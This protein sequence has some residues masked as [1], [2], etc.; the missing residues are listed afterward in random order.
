MHDAAGDMLGHFINESLEIQRRRMVGLV[1]NHADDGERDVAHFVAD[2]RDGGAFHFRAEGLRQGLAQGGGPGR[3]RDELIPADHEAPMHPRLRETETRPAFAGHVAQKFP[4]QVMRRRGRGFRMQGR[5]KLRLCQQ[6]NLEPGKQRA[7]IHVVLDEAVGDHHIPDA[8]ARV[9]S[10][11]HPGQNDLRAAKT[12]QQQKRGGRRR[13]L[14][15]PGEHQ[16]DLLPAPFALIKRPQ[17][18]LDRTPHLHGPLHQR[19]FLRHGSEN[20]KLHP[21]TQAGIRLCGYHNCLRE[22]DGAA[23]RACP[24]RGFA[25]TLRAMKKVLLIALAI[26]IV[27]AGSVL[28]VLRGMG[29][30]D[31]AL[32]L[33]A[34]T[35]AMAS[36]PD[37]PRSFLRWPQ[38]TLAKIG[39]EPQLKAF[40]EQPFKY[41]TQQ[42]GGDEAA[43]I[44]WSLKPGRIFAA[45][46]GVSSKDAAI[47][48]G[49]Q[50]WGGKPAHDAA[51]A[52]LRQEIALQGPAAEVKH[53]DYQGADIAS[54]VHGPVS[55]YNASHGQWGFISNNLP[56]LQEALDRA[57]GRRKE[58]SL[59]DSA[60]YKQVV[61]KL[62]RDPDLLVYVQPQTFLDA[63]LAVGESFGARQIPQQ[64]E[65]AR[66]I[67]AIGFATKLDGANIRD[68]IF[69]LRP[70][71]PD[72]GNLSHNSIKLTTAQ[73]TAFFDFVLDF[74]QF[75]KLGENPALAQA[76][77]GSPLQNSKLFQLAPEAFGPDCAVVLNW[78]AG[79]S[80]PEGVLALA[81]K[82]A[83]KAEQSLQEVLTLLP[84]TTVNDYAG[85]KY[86]SF[87]TLQKAFATPTVTLTDGF[88][89][90]GLDAA[91]IDRVHQAIKSG[92]SLENSPAFLSAKETY[93]SANEVF[94]Y[95]DIR[96]IFERGYPTVSQIVRFSAN[97]M[98]GMSDIIDASKLPDTET[99]AKHLQPIVYSQTRLADGY[100]V[101]S[102][103]PITMNQ[104]VLL[105][106]GAG[107]Y[108]FKPRAD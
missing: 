86:Y 31:A 49:F 96:A 39:V 60:R 34:E 63:L 62:S 51:V 61:A 72:T 7:R 6:G 32:L 33:P 59:A 107:A 57:A 28:W 17:P 75:A 76:L 91:E 13:D 10:A 9:H 89:L 42:Q 55:I 24:R 80:K 11:G 23:A 82:N 85:L 95:L 87:P 71:P 103:G 77:Q 101:E 54:S 78:P 66:K 68:S 16:D 100:L 90:V 26:L 52:R 41:L 36:L 45:S 21:R 14:P 88:A 12:L 3:V 93:R 38:T 48:V 15:H 73:T 104:A 44:L 81:V 5:G 97:F 43:G 40:L 18:R 69:V 106:A 25:V 84:E 27:I 47:L 64:I 83:A 22:R 19:N 70:S 8:Q 50:Y 99:I 2:L 67:E 79:Q 30:S 1:G 105:G 65:Q 37:L 20:S 92:D 56:A 46:V 29:V 98:P 94:G 108:F 4:A 102:T 53:E 74:T 58:G 35:V